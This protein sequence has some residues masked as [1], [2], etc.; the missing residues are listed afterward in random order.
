MKCERCNGTGWA[1]A[2]KDAGMSNA[3]DYLKPIGVYR[4]YGCDGTG[5]LGFEDGIVFKK[6]DNGKLKRI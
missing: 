2:A 1:S 3:P 4:C 6:F 5:N